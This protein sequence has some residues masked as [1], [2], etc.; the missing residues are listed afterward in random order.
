VTAADATVWLAI[1]IVGAGTFCIRFSFL[2][3]FEYLSAV[4]EGVQR[5]LRFVPAAVLAALVVPA[6]VVVDGT[7]AVSLENHRLLAAV[8]AAVVAW[9][10]ESIL[11]TIVVGMAVL[12]GLQV[13]L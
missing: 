7:P 9:R 4:P 10:T 2:F 6:V 5:T 13:V 11:A 12:L 8:V 3:L 1:A